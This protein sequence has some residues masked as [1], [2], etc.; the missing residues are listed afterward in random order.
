MRALEGGGETLGEE[1][2]RTSKVLEGIGKVRILAGEEGPW[3]DERSRKGPDRRDL[4][5]QGG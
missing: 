4:G 2:P 3:G 1:E 5:E